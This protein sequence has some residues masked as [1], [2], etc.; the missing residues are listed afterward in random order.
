[1][2]YTKTPI[3]IETS[4]RQDKTVNRMFE[5]LDISDNRPVSNHQQKN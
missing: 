3:T 5:V 2:L 4:T 1:M